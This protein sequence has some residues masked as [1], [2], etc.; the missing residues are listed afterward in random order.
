MYQPSAKELKSIEEW[1]AEYDALAEQG[2]LDKLADLGVFPMNVATDVPGGHAAVRQW[3]REEYLETMKEAM[4][5]GT[6]G[7]DLRSRRTPHFLSPNLV[8]VETRATMT[9]EGQEQEMHYADLLVRT[10]D[11]WAFQTMIQGGWGYGWPAARRG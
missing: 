1:F 11:G 2:E 8:V 6:A 4:G 9:V 7:L 10:E 5:G 3:T